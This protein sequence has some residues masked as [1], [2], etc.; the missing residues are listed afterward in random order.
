MPA[1]TA[2]AAKLWDW[3][4]FGPGEEDLTVEFD[5]AGGVTKV[6]IPKSWQ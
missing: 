4:L 3:R 2:E 1:P 6:T 5:A